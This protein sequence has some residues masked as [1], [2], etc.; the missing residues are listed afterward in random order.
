MGGKYEVRWKFNGK[1]PFW[2]SEFTNSLI[3]A[4]WLYVK[5]ALC[6]KTRV[7]LTMHDYR[8]C[9]VDCKERESYCPEYGEILGGDAS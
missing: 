2:E 7:D 1:C 5:A 3:N 9:P 4:L 6:G 8:E